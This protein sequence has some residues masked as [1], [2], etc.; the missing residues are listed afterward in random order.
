VPPGSPTRTATSSTTGPTIGWV[1]ALI[2]SLGFLPLIK[3][4]LPENLA[5]VAW[6]GSL[7]MFFG[8][9]V[10]FSEIITRYRDEPLRA[11]FNRY[12]VAYVVIN[13]VLSG[14]AFLVLVVAGPRM[15]P[16]IQGHP[17][18]AATM[19]GFGAMAIFRSKLFVFR[20]DDGKDV[21][22][23]PDVVI[24]SILRIVDRKV[25]RMR[26]ARRQQLVFEKAKRITKAAEGT[27][28]E[29]PNNFITISLASFQ[30]LSTEEKQQILAKSDEL[31]EKLKDRPSL[32]KA[33]VL[34]FMVLDLA[35]EDN[36]S[37]IMDDLE[38]YLVSSKA[39]P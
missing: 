32:F 30:N 1:L 34:G 7:A 2:L 13:G 20:T 14:T 31:K 36:F 22:I 6:F 35:G 25:D 5:T 33:M 38:D 18:V 8:E 27:D 39:A 28:F 23:G 37:G 3:G 26:A 24:S 21:P 11:T 29:N 10:G 9:L 19:A 17:L 4:F 15:F 12:G 16:D